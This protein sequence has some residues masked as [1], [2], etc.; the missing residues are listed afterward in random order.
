MGLDSYDTAILTALQ[1]D[2]TIALDDLGDIVNLSRNACWRRIKALEERGFIKRRVALLDQE[3]LGL[4]LQVF[5]HVKT[6]D[7]SPQ[8]AAKFAA[9]TRAIPNIVSV[10]RMSGDLDY[11]IRAW[12]ADIAAYDHLYQR[13]TKDVA[14]ADVSASFVMEDIKST[15]ELPL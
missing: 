1:R 2:C 15:T 7:H 4:G 6:N 3:K 11:L 8:W 13:L 5:I 10:H 14:I 12:V 9:A